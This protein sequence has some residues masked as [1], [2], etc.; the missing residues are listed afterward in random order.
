MHVP[1]VQLFGLKHGNGNT[2]GS[3]QHGWPRMPHAVH[4]PETHAL[5]DE[6]DVPQ[7]GWPVPP[8]AVH[9]PP[10]PQVRPAKHAVAPGQHGCDGP[11]HTAQWPVA[12]HPAPAPHV[13][14]A[15]HAPPTPP[16]A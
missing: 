9:A 2:V 4:A 7:H 15:Q 13:L 12:S 8:Q 16:H 3:V 5:P 6:H 10:E 1:A 11:P 14:P